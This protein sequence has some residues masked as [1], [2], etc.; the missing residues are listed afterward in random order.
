MDT[1]LVQSQFVD[2]SKT[3]FESSSTNV[4]PRPASFARLILHATD[5]RFDLSSSPTQIFENAI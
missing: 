3:Y 1:K 4:Q 5:A 2:Q